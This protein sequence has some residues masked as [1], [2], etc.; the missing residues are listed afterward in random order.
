MN[1]ECIKPQATPT[2]CLRS[3]EVSSLLSYMLL[4]TR[5][6]S[7]TF[8]P[9]VCFSDACWSVHIHLHIACRVC[10]IYIRCNLQYGYTVEIIVYFNL[11]V[12]PV[13]CNRFITQFVLFVCFV[14][15]DAAGPTRAMASTFLRFLDHTQRRTTVGRTPLDKWSARRRDL[16]LTTHNTQNRHVCPR[17]DSNPQSQQ[18]SARRPT[19]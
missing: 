16:Y 15:C 5:I 11:N 6:L 12:I 2:H 13:P 18:A 7:S 4:I 19:P 3:L 8:R 10:R 17:W 9:S 14:F 1:S